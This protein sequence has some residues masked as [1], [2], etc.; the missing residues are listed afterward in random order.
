[1][2]SALL[3]G[4]PHT[5]GDDAVGAVDAGEDDAADDAADAV[6]EADGSHPI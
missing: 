5:G 1:M 2:A 6:D 4:I 3:S